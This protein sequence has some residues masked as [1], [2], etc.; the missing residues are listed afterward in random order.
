MNLHTSKIQ[1]QKPVFTAVLEK[2][3][4]VLLLPHTELAVNIEQELQNNP[5]LEA[6]LEAAVSDKPEDSDKSQIDTERMNAIINLSSPHSTSSAQIE[7][8]QDFEP[9]SVTNMM[10]LE[11]HLFQQLFWEIA[12]P[13]KR[14]IGNFIISNLDKDG[15]FRLTIEEIAET[16]DI[17]DTLM[18]KEVLDSIQNF[19]PI[20][21]AAKD[22]KECL[23]VQLHSRQSPCR[24]LAIRIVE[25]YLDDLGNKRYAGLAKNL[26]VSVDEIN[27]AELLIASLEPKPARNF[28]T[29]DQ[30]I[31]VEPDLYLRKNE[32]GEYVVE[33][34]KSGLPRLRISQT[35]RN[36]L[37]QPNLSNEDRAFI[38]E[39]ITNAV[40]FMRSIEQ[41][42]ETLTAIA[43]LILER[44]KEFFD[45]ENPTL[46]PMTFKEVADHL[47][48]NESTISRAIS[49]KYIDT[50]QGLFPLKFFFSHNASRQSDESVSAHNVKQEL[51]QLIEEEN[52]G[53]PLS[54]LDIQAYFNAKGLHL[55]RRTITKYRQTLNIPSS[56]L[57]K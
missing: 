5:L 54:D 7:E 13:L 16:L 18:I 14:K 38:K 47:E 28:S 10:T 23:V 50:P 39:K 49:N 11:D 9:S 48:R 22:I 56:H 8:D 44:Q 17:N 32:A 6:D 19:D 46:S 57:R 15:F 52:K 29:N 43:S 3:I 24:D 35:Y 27:E 33:S 30:N 45:G 53:S 26:S 42:G 20:G 21:I 12:D 37:N 2:S 36:L 25:G 1:V 40:N 4:A 51:A 41:R 55:A 31:Y 34:N